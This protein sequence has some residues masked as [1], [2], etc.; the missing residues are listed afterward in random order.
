MSRLFGDQRPAKYAAALA[1]GESKFRAA[2]IAGYSKHQANRASDGIEKQPNVR[3]ALARYADRAELSAVKV[4]NELRRVAFSDLASYYNEDGS[5]IPF[6]ELTQDQRSALAS[7]ETIVKNAQAGDGQTD[8]VLKIKLHDKMKA[9]ELAAK[10]FHLV[11]EHV[12]V[13]TDVRVTVSWQKAEL[14]EGAAR[15][16]DVTPTAISEA[17]TVRDGGTP[18]PV[19]L[20]TE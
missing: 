1:Q 6:H 18:R 7:C 8:T 16:I 20:S 12:Q 19:K 3:R 10:H 5:F 9:L 14:P 2:L 13:D 17:D 15:I 11:D 4:L